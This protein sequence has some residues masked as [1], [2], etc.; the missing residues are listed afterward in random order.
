MKKSSLFHGNLVSTNRI[1]YTPSSFARNSLIHLQETG[2]LKAQSPHTSRRNHLDSYLFILVT[3]GSGSLTYN[4]QHYDLSA[5]DCAFI[6]CKLPYSHTTSSN[7]WSLQWVHFF[8]PNMPDIY[9]KYAERGGEPVFKSTKSALY[10]KMLGDL[11]EIAESEDY[12]RDMKIYQQ[13]LSLL[14]LLMEDSWHPENSHRNS[15]KRENLMELREYLD[16]HYLEHISLDELSEKFF[17]N[18]FYLTRIFKEQFG[19]SINSYITS[20]RITHAKQLLRFTTLSTSEIAEQCGMPDAN[21]F[22]RTFKKVE[23][24]TPGQFRKQW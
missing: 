18:K 7:L 8:G 16:D 23:G 12:L 15:P 6:D 2:T 24:I 21:Y 11:Y 3:E 4:G 19:V 9:A 5:G 10:S 17:I 13:L 14:T 22:S 20:L 1:L